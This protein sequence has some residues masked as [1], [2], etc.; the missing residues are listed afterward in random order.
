MFFVYGL[1]CKFSDRW[2]AGKVFVHVICNTETQDTWTE[3]VIT[4]KKRDQ[5]LGCNDYLGSN[6]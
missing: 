2:Q 4:L 5:L 1:L 3:I 6:K